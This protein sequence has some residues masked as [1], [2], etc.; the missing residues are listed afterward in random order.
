MDESGIPLSCVLTD[1]KTHDVTQVENVLEQK[2]LKPLEN[3]EQNLI[4]DKGYISYKAEKIM[5]NAGYTPY[6]P[7][8]DPTGCKVKNN[9]TNEEVV[10]IM[11][12]LKEQARNHVPKEIRNRRF[13]VERTHSWMNGCRKLRHRSDK[14]A[15]NYQAFCD[16]SLALIVFK[17]VLKIFI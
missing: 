3:T 11:E 6:I 1:A 8:R 16:L 4:C 7:K 14:I 13:V 2:V 10:K 12:T 9:T 5:K 15:A 17:R